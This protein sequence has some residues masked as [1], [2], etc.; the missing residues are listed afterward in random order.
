MSL[1]SNIRIVVQRHHFDKDA[2]SEKTFEAFAYLSL[3]TK[4]SRACCAAH[5]LSIVDESSV[6]SQYYSHTLAIHNGTEH[7]HSPDQVV[8]GDAVHYQYDQSC[9]ERNESC[10]HVSGK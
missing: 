3:S 7:A 9:S 4:T 10:K 8:G 2:D 6:P 5:C 1:A